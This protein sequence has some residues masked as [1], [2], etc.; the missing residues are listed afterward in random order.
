MIVT[1]LGR[2]PIEPVELNP[3]N[4]TDNSR[5]LRLRAPGQRK[6]I[7]GAKKTDGL[8]VP[9]LRIAQVSRKRLWRGGARRSAV[10]CKTRLAVAASLGQ[11]AEL[12]GYSFG[13]GKGDSGVANGSPAELVPDC[14]D[15]PIHSPSGGFDHGHRSGARISP[16]NQGIR[17]GARAAKKGPGASWRPKWR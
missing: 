16:R 10:I 14:V 15:G 5:H 11:F 7:R 2:W 4:F 1:T 8:V 3:V 6:F 13:G 9:D 17:E 12:I